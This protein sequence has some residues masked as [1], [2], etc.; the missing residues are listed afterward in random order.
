MGWVRGVKADWSSL[1]LLWLTWSCFTVPQ[2]SDVLYFWCIWR[3]RGVNHGLLTSLT[4]I[5]PTPR[6]PVFFSACVGAKAAISGPRAAVHKRWSPVQTA[7]AHATGPCMI[8]HRHSFKKQEY[9]WSII[10]CAHI[11]VDRS[12]YTN[13]YIHTYIH[14]LIHPLVHSYMVMCIYVYTGIHAHPPTHTHTHT[15]T[16]IYIHTYIQIHMYYH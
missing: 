14:T 15:P 6:T 2:R 11:H 10:G 8:C 5:G 3:A 7:K 9:N 16:H 12:I 4:F 13:T 1:L